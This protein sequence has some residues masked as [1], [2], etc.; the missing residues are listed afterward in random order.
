MLLE[1]N[2]WRRQI[3]EGVRCQGNN[4][5]IDTEQLLDSPLY[6]TNIYGLWGKRKEFDIAQKGRKV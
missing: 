6:K 5:Y 3:N 4:E 1:R 2:E